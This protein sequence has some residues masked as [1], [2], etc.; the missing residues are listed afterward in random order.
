MSGISEVAFGLQSLS[1]ITDTLNNQDLTWGEKTLSI[2]QSVA[3]GVPSLI[4]GLG[5][6][7]DGLTALGTGLSKLGPVIKAGKISWLS[8]KT[9]TDAAGV[10]SKKLMIS[11][12]GLKMSMGTFLLVIG[13]VAIAIGG[14]VAIWNAWKAR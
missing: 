5:Q 2:L 14:L 10:S 8:Y 4:N 12:L 13:A 11:I 7:T 6:V 1:T 9:T 3:F